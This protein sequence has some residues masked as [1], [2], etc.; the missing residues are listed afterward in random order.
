M[1]N[2]RR[3]RPDAGPKITPAAVEAYRA[4]DC[5]EL[6][7]ALNLPP[8]HPSPLQAEGASPYPGNCAGAHFWPAAVALREQLEAAV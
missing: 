2:Y 4:G 1:T 5:Q 8:W 3:R 7:R 6:H